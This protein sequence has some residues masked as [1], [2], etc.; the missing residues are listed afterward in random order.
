MASFSLTPRSR[1]QRGG[2]CRRERAHQK[3][4]KKSRPL[5][6]HIFICWHIG[7]DV[8]RGMKHCYDVHLAV[9]QIVL[10]CNTK[11]ESI[12]STQI[13]FLILFSAKKINK[14]GVNRTNKKD[15][16]HRIFFFLPSIKTA[17]LLLKFTLN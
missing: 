17:L 10:L 16:S 7:A 6:D 5:P 11:Y 1:R 4:K 8:K 13:V 12:I 14:K 2:G 9:Q 15:Q 3:K